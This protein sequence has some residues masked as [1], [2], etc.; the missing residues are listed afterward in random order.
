MCHLIESVC[1]FN[2]S[3]VPQS[4][5]VS[6]L[7]RISSFCPLVCWKK[8]P[9]SPSCDC[10]TRQEL[11]ATRKRI[12][13]DRRKHVWLSDSAL[14]RD[15]C[16]PPGRREEVG[17]ENKW[18]NSRHRGRIEFKML[19]L[20]VLP[21]FFS[22]SVFSFGLQDQGIDPGSRWWDVTWLLT[23]T[24]PISDLLVTCASSRVHGGG[25]LIIES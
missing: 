14:P 21:L 17:T 25:S 1:F 20:V 19:S 22:S 2:A 4:F 8:K 23:S 12:Q 6:I 3:R 9:E 11:S 7:W 13:S 5:A 16:W 10:Q 24:R 15:L 18:Q